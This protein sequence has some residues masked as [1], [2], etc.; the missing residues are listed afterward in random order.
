MAQ[1]RYDKQG[2]RL[3]DTGHGCGCRLCEESNQPRYERRAETGRGD[4]DDWSPLRRSLVR[5]VRSLTAPGS[6]ELA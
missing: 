2:R 1:A 4:R 3:P 5:L 6:R